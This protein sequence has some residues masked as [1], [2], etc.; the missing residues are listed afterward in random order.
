MPPFI[1]PSPPDFAAGPVATWVFFF[2]AGAAVVL[3]AL[4]WAIRAAAKD[5]NFIPILA[6]GGGFLCSLLEPMLDLLGHLRWANDQPTAFTNF[7]IDV[8][9]L[10]P[11][12]Y[13]AFLGLESYFCYYMLKKGITVKQCFMV[14]SV[15]I[16]TDAIMETVGLNLHIYEYYGIQPYTLFKFPYWWGF[17]NGVSFW[18]VGAI[19][20]FLVPRLKGAQRLWLLLAPPTGMMAAYFTVGWPHFLA[21][22][23]T[24]PTWA[25]WVATTIMMAMCLGLV[26]IVAY[27]AAVPEPKMHWTLPKIFAFRFMLPGARQRMLDQ[28]A[29][30]GEPQAAPR[31]VRQPGAV[32]R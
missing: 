18:T 31:H 4:P 28:M 22:N 24:L 2:V 13:A 7:G 11:P 3:I 27:F 14:F 23:S 5:R 9:W 1:L 26:R 12:C 32:R 25:K 8:P 15:G 29:A 16:F 17:I 20:W 6:I 21:L 30:E 10:I 19:M